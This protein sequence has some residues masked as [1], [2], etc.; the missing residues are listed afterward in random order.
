MSS[1]DSADK[2]VFIH[3]SDIHFVKNFSD[4]S[5]YDLDAA[6]RHAL[7]QDATK[8]L[9]HVGHVD[10]IL[11]SGD[12][13]FAGKV[14]EYE[15][16]RN[17]LTKLSSLVG[18]DAGYVWCVPG[19]HDV[20]QSVHKA[21]PT[22]LDTFSALRN[23]KRLD[24]DLTERLE[25]RENG[26][27]LFQPLKAYHEQFA[28]KY[29]C[30]TTPKQPW[31]EDDIT[32]N[33]GS[34]LRIRGLNS[35]LI[36]SRLD[37]EDT[38]KLILGSAQTQYKP[39]SHVT[40]LTLCHHPPDWL[41]DGDDTHEA[42]VAGSQLQ[43]FGHKHKHRH[44]TINQT[45]RLYSGAVHPV[46]KEKPWD[47]RYYFIVLKVEGSGDSRQ[48]VI[49]LFPRVW[50]KTSRTF[51][52]DAGDFEGQFI[53]ERLK[54]PNWKAPATPAAATT[55]AASGSEDTPGP[56]TL[57]KKKLINRFMLLPYHSQLTIL[58]TFDLFNEDER[59]TIP[60]TELFISCFQRAR[61]KGVLE[62]VWDAI[63]SESRKSEI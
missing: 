57:D 3:L 17:W 5:K 46:R 50:S 52:R 15:I 53:T 20:D 63:E 48:L 35:A 21:M 12:I 7:E 33:D 24:E 4:E 32:L 22:L 2:K 41:I 47:P 55:E 45:L 43:L 38:A 51:V 34:I 23:S 37:H 39:E 60:D 16:A 1:S 59:K 31:W 58:R 56:M 62:K 10:G 54:L 42:M 29:G 14:E 40:Y 49:E 9:D 6:L 44:E 13:A 30:P 26:P 8:M 25:S 36:S 27:L 61:E 28:A 19:N 18:C 11:I